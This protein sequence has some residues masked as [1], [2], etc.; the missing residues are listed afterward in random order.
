MLQ[1][2]HPRYL[3]VAR[4]LDKTLDEHGAIAEGGLGLGSGALKG[5]MQF[6]AG[7]YHTHSAATSTERGLQDNWEPKLLLWAQDDVDEFGVQREVCSASTLLQ[8]SSASSTV[9]TGASVPGTTWGLCGPKAV[10]NTSACPREKRRPWWLYLHS[11]GDRHLTSEHLVAHGA[12]HF[13]C[14]SDESDVVVQARLW[15]RIDTEVLMPNQS[16]TIKMMSV[17][18][19]WAKSPLSERKP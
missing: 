18:L 2:V 17:A 4:V 5:V 12:N 16:F 13:R 1:D 11:G 7:V 14:R 15:P 8:N 6:L 9:E 19:T 10:N 3:D